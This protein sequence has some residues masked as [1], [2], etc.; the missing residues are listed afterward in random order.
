MRKPNK[1]KKLKAS[2]MRKPI[3]KQKKIGG[4]RKNEQTK[5]TKCKKN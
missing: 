5:N 3:E 2:P 4:K 1:K